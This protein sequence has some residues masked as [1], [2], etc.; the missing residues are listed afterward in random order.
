MSREKSVQK[1]K[2]DNKL[3]ID[4]IMKLDEHNPIGDVGSEAVEQ[5]VKVKKINIPSIREILG[6]PNPEMS[7]LIE[8]EEGKDITMDL[9]LDRFSSKETE[10]PQLS[11]FCL[12]IGINKKDLFKI[13]NKE[14]PLKI[15]RTGQDFETRISHSDKSVNISDV[16]R[17]P[18]N[19][20]FI[21]LQN[22]WKAQDYGKVR[23]VGID[24][25]C[26]RG[27]TIKVEIPWVNKERRIRF[28][29]SKE[30][31]SLY[32]SFPAF[33]KSMVGRYP[34]N[35]SEISSII[36]EEIP[37]NY[38]GKFRMSDKLERKID[39]NKTGFMEYIS[40]NKERLSKKVV[41][42]SFYLSAF[43]LMPPLF[44]IPLALMMYISTFSVAL[45][46][47]SVITLLF[48]TSAV[49]STLDA[50]DTYL[51]NK[52]MDDGVSFGS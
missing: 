41:Y 15:S 4:S 45:A 3:D 11:S 37:V 27:I 25:V 24:T 44:I 43:Y 28:S 17:E 50:Y 10:K 35:I 21:Q 31:N 29:N 51:G 38:T 19:W 16:E 23:V 8:T 22:L 32:P 48:I 12:S 7:I 52:P 2:T 26:D 33:Y 34:V 42:N 47:A 39:K 49:I 13:V 36:G 46:W 6:T 40:N 20:R 1:D 30:W 5:M 14:I 9:V 18:K